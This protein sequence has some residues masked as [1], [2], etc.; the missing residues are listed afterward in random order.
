MLD[1]RSWPEFPFRNLV[2]Q[3][4][5]KKV[6]L[7]KAMARPVG[8]VKVA[9]VLSLISEKVIPAGSWANPQGLLDQR[10]TINENYDGVFTWHFDAYKVTDGDF[11]NAFGMTLQFGVTNPG[12][13]WTHRQP[14]STLA[15]HL[16]GF[17]ESEAEYPFCY[18]SQIRW[19]ILNHNPFPV[20]LSL[21]LK[22]WEAR[23]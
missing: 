3:T 23:R 13:W 4:E 16:P 14:L 9:G 10:K 6:A 2:G 11:P 18:Q 1:P 15:S 8:P 22:Y 20:T 17:G 5:N 21:Y 12:A 19:S 7:Q